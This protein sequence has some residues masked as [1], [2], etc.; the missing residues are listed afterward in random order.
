MPYMPE[1][2]GSPYEPHASS[3]VPH[4]WWMNSYPYE[5]NWLTSE[6]IL[7]RIKKEAS[8][9]ELYHRLADE[10]PTPALRNSMIHAIN[11]KQTLFHHLTGLY[12]SFTGRQP[13]YPL[14]IIP[15]RGYNDGL[16]KAYEEGMRN[17]EAYHSNSNKIPHPMVQHTWLHA[18][19]DELQHI[20]LL[21]SLKRI[22]LQDYGSQP[23][24]VDIEEAAKQNNT[25]RTALWTGDHLQ[26]TLMSIGVGEDIG[27]EVHPTTDQFIRIEEGQGLVQ[28]GDSKDKLDYQKMAYEDY[29]IMIPAG[30]WH[31]LTNKGNKPLKVY[32]IYAPPEHPFGTVHRTRA[33]ALASEA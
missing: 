27:L 25:Y 23:F 29:A 19:A 7:E 12:T 32:V 1:R 26:V 5:Q 18:A 24:V 21:R 14:E 13:S 20:S 33:D 15:Y 16:I 17:A 31:N 2:Y 8:F 9:I 11:Y 4:S 22:T 30:K 10:A 28:M 3:A 6:A